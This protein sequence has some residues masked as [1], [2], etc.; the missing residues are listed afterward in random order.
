MTD[1]DKDIEMTLSDPM[2]SWWPYIIATIVALITVVRSYI[3]GKE[4][5][6][7]KSLQGKVVIITGANSGIGFEVA[8][9]MA[10]R[11]A[12]VV[13]ACR[14]IERARSAS[15]QILKLFPSAS[16]D[17]RHIDLATLQSVVDFVQN[18]PYTSINLLI[19][20][21][22]VVFQPF[23]FTEDGFETHFQVNY[24]GHFLLTRLL[25]S[26]M[27]SVPDARVISMTSQSHF[28][29]DI[30]LHDLNLQINYS[31]RR[32]Y[33]QSK[34]ALL[35]MT[36]YLGLMLKDSNVNF[37]AVN[38]GLVRGT[39]HVSSSPVLNESLLLRLAMK[40][41]MWLFM[42]T[43]KQGSQSVLYAAL[44]P[45]VEKIRGAYICDCSV[46]SPS[47]LA[48]DDKLAADLFERSLS[49]VAQKA[50][51]AGEPQIWKTEKI[52]EN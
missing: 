50:T 33:G 36:R 46:E 51:A 29:A 8:C 23:A 21:A 16:I 48:S 37:L 31:A 5:K 27:C 4:F 28:A 49:L 9:D 3:G 19:L 14:N 45:Q 44:D 12:Q 2:E 32:A 52:D 18:L 1:S 34:L 26:R 11:G 25:V 47:T 15:K 22:G 7:I 17:V 42:K 40:P 43:P 30:C 38:P 20:N 41:L 24:L 35:L 6:S 13:M 39:K 10:Q